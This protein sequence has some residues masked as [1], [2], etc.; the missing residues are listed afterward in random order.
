M[1]AVSIKPLTTWQEFEAMLELD[2]AVWGA[3]EPVPLHHIAAVAKNGGILLG[4]YEQD[5]LIGFIYSFPGYR[6]GE[7]YL[8]SHTMAVREGW[9]RVGI[10]ERLKRAQA[11]AARAAGYYLVTWTYDPLEAVNGN[12]NIGKLGGVCANYIEECY[13]QMNDTLNQG[14]ASDRFQVAWWINR[15]EHVPPQGE[16]QKLV[17]WRLNGDNLTAPVPV[18]AVADI[19][20]GTKVVSV[21][22]PAD[23]QR[24]KR[25]DG[26][27]AQVWRKVTRQA[28]TDASHGGW[29]VT[30]FRRKPVG[31]AHEYLLTRQTDMD[32]P[33]APWRKDDE[34]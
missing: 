32:L 11:D 17:D 18:T 10:G 3:W 29:M 24:I 23:I 4:A 12:L 21:A 30:G 34:R 20:S 5:L 16:E 13:G 25:H 1:Q 19:P 7:H 8:Y 6:G 14:M 31:P 26:E 28:F 2:I 27:L 9:R 15:P 22:V 33:L